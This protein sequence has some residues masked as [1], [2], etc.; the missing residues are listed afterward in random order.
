MGGDEGAEDV[1]AFAREARMM[2][3]MSGEPL[4]A[5][6]DR[7]LE[8]IEHGADPDDVFG[9]MDATLPPPDDTGQPD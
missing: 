6:F 7:A 2:A 4:D 8:H 5:E 3:A 9:E 1:A